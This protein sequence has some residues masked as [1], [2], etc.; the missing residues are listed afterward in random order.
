MPRIKPKLPFWKNS[1]QHVARAVDM[2]SGCLTVKKAGKNT[3]TAT[4][5]DITDKTPVRINNKSR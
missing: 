4:H 1:V 2:P 3:S 5:P